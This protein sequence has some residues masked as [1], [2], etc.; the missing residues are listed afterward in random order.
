MYAYSCLSSPTYATSWRISVF[1]FESVID[2]PSTDPAPDVGCVMPSNILI[3]VLLPAPLRPRKPV[4]RWP[5]TRRLSERTADCI[6][7]S[8][9]LCQLM[10]FNDA[11]FGHRCLSNRS[12]PLWLDRTVLPRRADAS[13]RPTN[14]PC[15][16]IPPE[17][18]LDFVQDE[19]FRP[20]FSCPAWQR[21][22]LPS[23]A[24]V[25]AGPHAPVPNRLWRQCCG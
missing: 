22:K 2:L 4:I 7:V 8:V 15:E 5:V 19:P 6:E 11:W 25:P 1:A 16:G 21:R 3:V 12:A 20:E 9:A 14:L 17:L 24:G 10:G 18:E 23:H 13:L